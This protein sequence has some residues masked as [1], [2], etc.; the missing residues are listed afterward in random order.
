MNK[1]VGVVCLVATAAMAMQ[2]HAGAMRQE[3]G[4][5]TWSAATSLESTGTD[6]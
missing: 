1:Q 6:H 5:G 3:N 4:F 2:R